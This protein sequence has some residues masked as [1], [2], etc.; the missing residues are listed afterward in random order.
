MKRWERDRGEEEEENGQNPNMAYDRDTSLRGREKGS[1]GGE[2]ITGGDQHKSY[3][4]TDS[5]WKERK[6]GEGQMNGVCCRMIPNFIS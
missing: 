1:G 4:V 6:R 5:S 3:L 2:F